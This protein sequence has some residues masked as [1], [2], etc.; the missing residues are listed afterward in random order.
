M[1]NFT[2]LKDGIS[3]IAPVL[4]SVI[5][6]SNPIAGLVI[7]LIA[8]IFGAD[9]TDSTDI[10]N[11][12]NL[13]PDAANKLK[14]LEIQHE[15]ILSSN[16]VADRSN[17]RNREIEITKA[18]GKRDSILEIIAISVVIGYLL[19]CGVIIFK[20]IDIADHDMLNMLFGQLMG[21]FIMVLSYFFGSSNK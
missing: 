8:K 5:S 21:G 14:E 19:M 11:K 10:I 3:K 4:G 20:P 15:N 12:I 6:A 13:D 2:E 1:M 16:A 17:A 18:T 9:S 7:S